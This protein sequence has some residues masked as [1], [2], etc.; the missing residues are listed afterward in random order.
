[1]NEAKFTELV[2]LYFDQELSSLEIE[3]LRNELA[4][5]PDRRREFEA[6]YRLHQG[7]RVAL[8]AD[9]LKGEQLRARVA[10]KTFHAAG[11]AAWVFGSGVAACVTLGILVLRP[12][13][14]DTAGDA[15]ADGGAEMARVDMDR[16][17]ATRAAGEARRGSLISELR[18]MGLTPEM[19]P[20]GRQLRTVD[21][22]ALRQREA[23][24]LRMIERI[25]QYKAYSAMP[26]PQLFES[27]GRSTRETPAQRWPAGFRSSLASF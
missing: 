2:N 12:A 10:R 19:A 21:V 15:T 27:L 24:R 7:M 25:N 11:L 22:E 23:R 5:N 14:Q 18:L 8:A 4:D 6:R 26:E 9:A 16:F 3:W 17:A 20:V 13:L 1:M